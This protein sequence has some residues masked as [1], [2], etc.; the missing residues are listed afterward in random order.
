V[1]RLREPT[2]YDAV[3]RVIERRGQGAVYE[4]LLSILTSVPVVLL[5]ERNANGAANIRERIDTRFQE[6]G[7]W[8]K[9]RVGG[10]DWVKQIT[11]GAENQLAVAA[12]GVEIQV[13]GRNTML[14]R[15]VSH[16]RENLRDAKIGAG[17]IVAPD[18]DLAYCL[19]DRIPSL[20]TAKLDDSSTL[21]CN[22]PIV[23]I[24]A[25][26]CNGSLQ[27]RPGTRLSSAILHAIRLEQA[28]DKRYGLRKP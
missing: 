6:A 3:V 26:R 10:V 23:R 9:T 25:S 20:K 17:I 8:K 14:Y 19:T 22:L 16:L 11:P 15:D 21:W 27:G 5:Q 12:L 13:S 4:E 2:D 28:S 1:A 18:D 7:G 24:A